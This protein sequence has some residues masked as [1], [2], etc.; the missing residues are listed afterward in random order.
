MRQE[1]ALGGHRIRGAPRISERLGEAL[2]A[3]DRDGDPAALRRRLLSLV[4]SL[5]EDDE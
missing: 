5:D 4:M 2:E 3:W 1:T